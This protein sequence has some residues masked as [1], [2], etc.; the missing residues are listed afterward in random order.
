MLAILGFQPGRQPEIR[1]PIE[2]SLNS[3]KT[4]SKQNGDLAS[5]N[6]Q[7][8]LDFVDTLGLEIDSKSI[9][10]HAEIGMKSRRR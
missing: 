10:C 6:R 7:S 3:R 2:G 9:D 1:G 5:G 4:S 8:I